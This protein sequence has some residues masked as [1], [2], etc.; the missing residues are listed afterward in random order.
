[1]PGVVDGHLLRE[2]NQPRL[3]RLVRDI[4]IDLVR[5]DGRDRQDHAAALRAH[6]RKRVLAAHH[7]AAEVHLADAV[8]RG[9][10]DLRDRR[11]A[12][13]DA[14]AHVVV[15]H[16]DPPPPPHRL[17][18]RRLERR[19]PRHVGL[20]RR[21]VRALAA[22]LPGGL[23]GEVAMAVN[24][25]DAG[26]LPREPQRGGAAVADRLARVLAG[27]DD[28]RNLVLEAHHSL[29]RRMCRRLGRRSSHDRSISLPLTY[30]RGLG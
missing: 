6:D 12:A 2:G 27:A 7:G 24:G 18:H 11:V 17:G 13:L 25:E 1:M 4:G 26:T 8:E 14:D 3:G 20:E 10:G 21:A 22:G 16:V 29:P 9:L 19:L 5:G 30:W 15:Q 28:D 23:L